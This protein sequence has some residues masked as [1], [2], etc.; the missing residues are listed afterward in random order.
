[1]RLGVNATVRLLPAKSGSG[2]WGSRWNEA[3]YASS[4]SMSI[5]RRAGIEQILGFIDWR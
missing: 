1:M 4:C 3:V 2:N 5:N